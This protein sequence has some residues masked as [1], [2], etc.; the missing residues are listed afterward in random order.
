MHGRQQPRLGAALLRCLGAAP[1][2]TRSSRRKDAKGKEAKAAAPNS[3]TGNIFKHITLQL[4][5][6]P[7]TR[8]P[9][10]PTPF[11]QD[12]AQ[13]AAAAAAAAVPGVVS[14]EQAAAA[15]QQI[16]MQVG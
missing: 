11:P 1:E 15:V 6:S 7:H 13:Q 4:K 5:D 3:R 12:P 2:L 9:L 16:M 14:A 8:P 10:A